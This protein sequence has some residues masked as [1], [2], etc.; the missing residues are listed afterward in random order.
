MSADKIL[1]MKSSA[2]FVK[3]IEESELGFDVLAEEKRHS[4]RDFFF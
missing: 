3:Q 2:P 1:S 4:N